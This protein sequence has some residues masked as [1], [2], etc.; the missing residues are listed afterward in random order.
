[1]IER[2]INCGMQSQKNV[3]KS[4]RDIEKKLNEERCGMAE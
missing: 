4:Y 1:M 3:R 2:I